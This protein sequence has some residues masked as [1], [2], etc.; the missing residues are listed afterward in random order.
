MEHVLDLLPACETKSKVQKVLAVLPYGSSLYGT[1]T[2][3]SDWDYKLIYLPHREGYYFERPETFR[4]VKRVNN[5]VRL[6]TGGAPVQPG[7]VEFECVPLERFFLDI[8]RGQTYALELAS[9]LQREESWLEIHAQ[10]LLSSKTLKSSVSSMVGFAKKQVFDYVERGARHNAYQACL[11]AITSVPAKLSQVV[12]AYADEIVGACVEVGGHASYNRVSLE[13]ELCGRTFHPLTPIKDLQLHCES[14]L[15]KFGLRSIKAGESHVDLKS[16]VHA[17][18]CYEQ[19]LEFMN[20]GR[21]TF[22]RPNAEYLIAAKTGK[23]PVEDIK[24]KLSVLSQTVETRRNIE[25]AKEKAEN[26]E[27]NTNLKAVKSYIGL[28]LN[29]LYSIESQ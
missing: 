1:R 7:E 10:Y 17:V 5:E 28:A 4:V 20:Y 2:E 23:I 13:L 29:Q 16:L 24:Q 8:V 11:L 18:R 25:I 9:S 6:Y 26:Q 19:A 22:P 3:T 14:Q 12:A 15:A 27:F 21:I